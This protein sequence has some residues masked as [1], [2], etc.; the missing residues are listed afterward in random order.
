M[1]LIDYLETNCSF[2]SVSGGTQV[3]LDE[4]CPFCGS[5]GG[6]YIG[7]K[8]E[9]GICFKCSQ[10]F[11]AISFVTAYES[12][13]RGQAIKLLNGSGDRYYRDEEEEM[14]EE[15]DLW[16]PPCESF[17][18][19]ALRYMEDRGFPYEFCLSVGL[20]F[21]SQNVQTKDERI[22]YTNN[23][24]IIPIK[25]RDGEIISWQGR[26]ITCK[27]KIKYLFQPGFK[28]A[29]YLYNIDR[30]EPGKP[31]ILV[32]GVMDAWGWIR[33]GFTNVL[34][35]WG[36]KI[37]EQQM[38]Q[39]HE[40]N[41]GTVYMAWDGDAWQERLKFVQQYGHLFDVLMVQ[42]GA[43][44]AD[45]MEMTELHELYGSATGHSWDNSIID[46]LNRI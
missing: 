33:A 34:A 20:M 7:V 40:M 24:I 12:I 41:P 45:E 2:D 17:P 39:I 38:Q 13:S 14:T 27:S 43:R 4:D 21:C 3:L 15:P 37:S 29:E 46:A 11:N 28:G 16:F 44:D 1:S 36:K 35:T 42:M 30:I 19:V 25:N 5:R 9:I 10:G 8:K 31:I 18:D 26:D 23:R 32:E 22:H 6:I